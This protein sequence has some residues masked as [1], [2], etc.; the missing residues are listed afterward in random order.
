M[1]SR[2]TEIP[3]FHSQYLAPV[4][5]SPGVTLYNQEVDVLLL[6]QMYPSISLDF[7]AGGSP[8]ATC[9]LTGLRRKFY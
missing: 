7:L 3:T 9:T 6:P 2:S 8:N 1:I 4:E 5:V